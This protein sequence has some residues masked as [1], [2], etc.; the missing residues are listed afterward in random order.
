MTQAYVFFELASANNP[1]LGKGMIE[2][3][4]QEEN[5]MNKDKKE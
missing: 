2:D 4:D 3:D 1:S 5:E